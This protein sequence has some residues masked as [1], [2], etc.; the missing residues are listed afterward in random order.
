M[1]EASRDAVTEDV[2]RNREM[3][4]IV[5]NPLQKLPENILHFPDYVITQM[6]AVGPCSIEADYA[7]QQDGNIPF[8]LSSHSSSERTV[9]TRVKTQEFRTLLARFAT[10]VSLDNHYAGQVLF[11]CEAEKDGSLRQHRFSLFLCNEPTMGF[12]LRLYLYS[13][14]GLFPSFDKQ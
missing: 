1:P 9:V 5:L 14:D 11:S 2:G 6:I 4:T 10:Q 7:L 12:W 13:I 3:R 8:T